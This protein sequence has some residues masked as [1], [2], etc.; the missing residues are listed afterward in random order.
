MTRSFVRL[1]LQGQGFEDMLRTY[2]NFG[3]PALRIDIRPAA[4]QVE[5][6]GEDQADGTPLLAD[7]FTDSLDVTAVIS[8]DVDLSSIRVLDGTRELV[9]NNLHVTP[10][11]PG[12]NGA[13]F[14]RVGF[15]TVLRLEGAPG[16]DSGTGAVTHSYDVSLEAV[17]W[18]GRAARFAFPVVFRT[19]FLALEPGGTRILLPNTVNTMEQV[20]PLRVVA[21]SPVPLPESSVELTV[22]GEPVSLQAQPDSSGR[23]WTLEGG[24]PWAKGGH[25]AELHMRD[26][27]GHS[28]VSTVQFVTD[29]DVELLNSNAY[30]GKGVVFYPNPAEGGEGSLLYQLNRQAQRAEV[31]AY[32]VRGRRVFTADAPTR[33]G[34]NSFRWDLRDEIGDPVGNGVYLFLLRLWDVNG[35]VTTTDPQRV[36]VS[37]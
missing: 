25:T 11:D 10:P 15:K 7:S 5:V 20:T 36:V 29:P 32:T 23:V 22:D 12:D 24:G 16:V 4:F 27:R 26:E 14:Y 34:T 2:Q 19:T 33:A 1:A 6:N 21:T 17:D 28:I 18:A 3:D 13:Q 31:T 9:G 8:D 30:G 35:D 37:R